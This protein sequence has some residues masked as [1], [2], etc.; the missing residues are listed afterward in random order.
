MKRQ[1]SVLIGDILNDYIPR[2]SALGQGLLTARIR[3]AYS[4]AVGPQAAAATM[5]VSFDEGTLRCRISSSVL[6]MLLTLNKDEITKNINAIL[7]EEEVQ[8]LMFT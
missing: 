5:S 6:R 1:T 3:K 7:G 2:N 4:Q 8:S